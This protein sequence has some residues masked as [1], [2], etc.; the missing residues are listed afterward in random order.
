MSIVFSGVSHRLIAVTIDGVETRTFQDGHREYEPDVLKAKFFEGV[1]CV[2]TWGERTNNEVFEFLSDQS[3][4]AGTHTVID[5]RALVSEYL[6]KE[7]QPDQLGLGDVGYH[8]TGFDDSQRPHFFH[9]VWGYHRPRRPE[10]KTPEY[11]SDDYSPRQGMIP[12]VYNGRNDLAERVIHALVEEIRLNPQQ[13]RLRPDVT[14]DLAR[15][16]DLIARFAAELTPEVGPPFTTYLISPANTG[17]IIRND[18]LCPIDKD[19]AIRRLEE[20]GYSYQ[21]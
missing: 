15:I 14:P 21:P 9:E 16:G 3:I 1:G 19:A 4:S 5:L 11:I 7:Y 6:R 8:I 2:A 13:V 18:S 12:L 10:Q 20:L 17:A